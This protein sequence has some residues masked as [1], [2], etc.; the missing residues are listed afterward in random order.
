ML[1]MTE[2][3]NGQ[4]YDNKSDFYQ[5]V[6][7]TSPFHITYHSNASEKHPEVNEDHIFV[8][9]RRGLVAIFDG[10]GGRGTGNIATNIAAQVI[11]SS[12]EHLFA[13]IQEK[14]ALSIAPDHVSKCD[15]LRRLI[16]AINEQIYAAGGKYRKTEVSTQITNKPPSATAAIVLLYQEEENGYS[17]AFAHVGDCRI[18]LLRKQKML[19]RLTEDDGYYAFL[20]QK[21]VIT[22]VDAHRID[23]A[24]FP[25]QLSEK[26]LH[27]FQRRNKII[28]AL[29]W[30]ETVSM[31]LDHQ[32]LIPGDRILL[33]T[34][35]VHDNLTDLE[36]KTLL[37]SKETAT[38]AQRIVYAASLRA[39]E[40]ALRAKMDDISA[41][42][43]NYMER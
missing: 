28:Q 8:D 4:Q 21:G 5:R 12:W 14:S 9:E 33:C 29:G 27:I 42:V 31:H 7:T 30:E 6:L 10:V 24:T 25:D 43:I 16:E 32:V 13:E 17:M 38:I 40:E 41:I 2:L 19:H 22:Q 15:Q 39:H 34:D 37:E 3:N 35:G 18:Y 11:E 23:Q 1:V 36:I 20:V 26:E